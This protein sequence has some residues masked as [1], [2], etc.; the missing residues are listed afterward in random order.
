MDNGANGR[1]IFMPKDE[2]LFIRINP[3]DK[4]TIQEGA[5]KAGE[6][7]TNYTVTAAVQKAKRDLRKEK[8]K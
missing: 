2:R 4:E 8:N 1:G 3:S 7:L 5:D 6:T